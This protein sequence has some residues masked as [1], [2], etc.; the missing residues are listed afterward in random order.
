M[1]MDCNSQIPNN[2]RLHAGSWARGY[3]KNLHNLTHSNQL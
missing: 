1:V 3:A 2:A